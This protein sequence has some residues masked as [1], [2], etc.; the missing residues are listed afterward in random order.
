[1]LKKPFKR[2]TNLVTN[3]SLYSEDSSSDRDFVFEKILNVESLTN[4]NSVIDFES[5]EYK[6]A[7]N[8]I[9]F[10][11]FFLTYLLKDEINDIKNYIEPSFKTYSDKVLKL[12]TSSVR[13]ETLEIQ[14][15]DGLMAP[16]FEGI[17]E[18]TRTEINESKPYVV[19]D[20]LVEI[21]KN[22]PGK[23]GYPHFYNT[24]A[25]PFW[26]K[27]DAWVNLKYGF[28]NKTYMY[29]SFMIIE[30]Y[31]TYEVEKQKKITTI[32]VYASD[33]Y[34]FK[35]KTEKRSYNVF[36][37]LGR[38]IET[39]TT[40]GI[41]QKRP[42][43]KLSEGID[44]YSFFFLKKY[45]KSDFYARFY[46]WDALNGRKI[47]FIP[48]AKSNKKKKWL[49]D[50][51]VF[52]QKNLY[53]K[54]ELD[55][56]SKK[57]KIFDL[58]GATGDFDIEVDKIDLYEFAYDDYWSKFFVE[59]DQP[60]N[61]IQT[62]LL[63]AYRNILPLKEKVIG[64]YYLTDT[65]YL[66]AREGFLFEV[67][68]IGV[69]LGKE[70]ITVTNDTG[71]TT[72]LPTGPSS[73]NFP[74]GSGPSF[75]GFSTGFGRPT[76][77]G[78]NTGT[79]SPT[80]STITIDVIKKGNYQG[81]FFKNATNI[82]VKTLALLNIRDIKC[83]LTDIKGSKK[84]IEGLRLKNI[85]E[86]KNF[87]INSIILENIKFSSNESSVDLSTTATS[88]YEIQ[89]FPTGT[90]LYTEAYVL[91]KLNNKQTLSYFKTLFSNDYEIY[92]K[93]YEYPRPDTIP[94]RSEEVFNN[95]YQ[96]LFTNMS[97]LEK[98]VN[99]PLNVSIVSGPG[100]EYTQQNL[101]QKL[102]TDPLLKEQTFA[103]TA[104]T[105]SKKLLYD[106]Q[107]VISLNVVFGRM[108]LF[109]SGIIKEMNIKGN[110]VINYS[111]LNDSN[112]PVE[113]IIIPININ[114]K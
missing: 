62:E 31:D 15:N 50:V 1:M 79:G 33:R 29:N 58:N 113:K 103:L 41:Y 88:S 77:G 101:L 32:P 78:F 74:T 68:P 61:N 46:F 107:M 28:N 83:G 20:P 85:N 73:G 56:T 112:S 59:N 2:D 63:P 17:A 8:N 25:L 72:T 84:P 35:E 102:V 90:D 97:V 48:S 93:N 30:I 34:L 24:F 98:N 13:T 60:T 108:G 75:G 37:G 92:K 109:Y 94:Q 104:S 7:S 52:D 64:P 39:V 96:R 71:P 27:K 19:I 47:E 65:K 57:Y 69:E 23:P 86:E 6:H 81:Y 10:D 89:N 70:T 110:L 114:L 100:D 43:F 26:G 66:T 9:Q 4:I 36:D 80:T 76:P 53:L 55:Y 106:E 3:I 95:L 111:I 45:I 42:V 91:P 99:T 14:D 51:E 49:Q 5:I 16:Q 18:L 54:Y 87:L 82:D 105:D 38:I 44:G 67:E 40:E 12:I 22:Y 21:R 11:I